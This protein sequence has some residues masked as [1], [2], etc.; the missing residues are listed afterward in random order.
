MLFGEGE[1]V[2]PDGVGVSVFDVGRSWRKGCLAS[3]L[4]T[5]V[6]ACRPHCLRRDL[7][8]G[9]V[10]CVCR[11]SQRVDG[12]GEERVGGSSSGFVIYT[13]PPEFVI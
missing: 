6:Q 1:N 7:A 4:S 5:S 9:F 12:I 2:V 10:S 11:H 3:C 13:S 8:V